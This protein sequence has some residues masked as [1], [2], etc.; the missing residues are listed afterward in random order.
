MQ[1]NEPPPTKLLLVE[2]Q[3]DRRL[4]E[5][6]QGD[7]MQ[8]TVFRCEEKGSSDR[9]L[10]G[11]PGEMKVDG[12]LA[13]GIMMDADDVAAR[14]Q[15]IGS[16]LRQ[17]GVQL[18]T[19]PKYRG[20]VIDSDPRVGVWLMPDNSAPGVLENF[21]AELV[22]KDDPVWP[23]AEQ[24]IDS[25]AGEHRQF[26]QEKELRAKLHLWL[27]TREGTRMSPAN[28]SKG[29]DA[30][31][32]IVTEF[33]DWLRTLFGERSLLT[34]A[35]AMA[36][37]ST[38]RKPQPDASAEQARLRAAIAPL[39]GAVHDESLQAEDSSLRVK[40]VLA[41]KHGRSQEQH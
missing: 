30:G 18:P 22:P 27:A 4:V 19:Q 34:E 2:G 28:E 1:G 3:D 20:T 23:L 25:I 32:R 38:A 5:H 9:L 16:R 39:I 15:S 17:V 7:C 26:P 31:G 10:K 8:G 29:P 37:D 21:V 6:L 24:Y 33:T 13:L 35:S 41:E 40:E 36:A 12:R 14:W 11:I